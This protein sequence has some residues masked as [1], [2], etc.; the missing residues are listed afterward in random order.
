MSLSDV[1]L[2]LV[3]FNSIGSA[4]DLKLSFLDGEGGR[5]KEVGKKKEGGRERG[6]REEGVGG[7]EGV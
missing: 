3:P 6:G 7:R 5:R 1:G 2:P 4:R